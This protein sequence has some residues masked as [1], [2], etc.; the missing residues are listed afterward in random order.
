[1]F[2]PKKPDDR[3][4]RN[5]KAKEWKGNQKTNHIFVFFAFENIFVGNKNIF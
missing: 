4:D 1:M 3:E 2:F 5:G